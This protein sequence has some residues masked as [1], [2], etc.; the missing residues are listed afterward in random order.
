VQRLLEVGDEDFPAYLEKQRKVQS[1]GKGVLKP[2]DTVEEQEV[3]PFTTVGF[4]AEFI[5]HY[6]NSPLVGI[7][8]LELA[9]STTPAMAYTGIPFKLETDAADVIELV[10]PPFL[11]RTKLDAP[12]PNGDDIRKLDAGLRTWLTGIT[13]SSGTLG[14]VV[15][16]L[17]RAGLSFT[18]GSMAVG[19]EHLSFRTP[20]GNYDA[21]ANEITAKRLSDLKIGKPEKGDGITTQVNFAT[22]TTTIAALRELTSKS[23]SSAGGLIL[24]LRQPFEYF[25]REILDILEKALVPAQEKHTASP[26]LQ[27]MIPNFLPYLSRHI[28]GQIAV[29]GQEHLKGLQ[30]EL[31][32]D[33]TQ[34]TPILNSPAQLVKP[35]TKGLKTSEEMKLLAVMTSIVKDID[36]LWVKSTLPTIA[37]SFLGV[38]RKE[39]WDFF[40]MLKWL[41]NKSLDQVGKLT[42]K[43]PELTGKDV[44]GTKELAKR[45]RFW[46]GNFVRQGQPRMVAAIRTFG[47]WCET[48]E[49]A[50]TEN[51]AAAGPELAETEFLA[52][53]EAHITPRQDTLIAPGNVQ[54]AYWSGKGKKLHVVESRRASAATLLKLWEK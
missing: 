44:G 50:I 31:Y 25:E 4:E 3:E 43:A 11:V 38:S 41:C 12:V 18:L 21:T 26:A 15:T 17:N 29:E 40:V 32:K 14:Q 51:R 23:Q 52:H 36:E 48:A 6:D 37:L 45:Y 30:E 9:E 7:S 54:I 2:G 22:D 20:R 46:L 10:T 34:Q 1:G 5:E 28:A 13:E 47:A 16:G 35:T 33:K 42:Y 19:R 53:S 39:N 27:T 8:H 49:K 24:A